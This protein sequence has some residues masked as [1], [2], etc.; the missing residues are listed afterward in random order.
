MML[1]LNKMKKIIVLALVVMMVLTGVVQAAEPYPQELVELKAQLKSNLSDSAYDTCRQ[2]LVPIYDLE[3]LEFFKYL[4]ETFE[5]KSANSTLTNLAI[6]R[7]SR[8]RYRLYET[9][10][11]LQPDASGGAPSKSLTLLSNYNRCS[12]ITQAYVDL[13]KAKLVEHVKKNSFQKRSTVLLEKYQAIGSRLKEMNQAIA[14]MYSNY[15]A[16]NNKLPGFLRQCIQN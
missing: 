3:L 13:G 15:V 4:E 12:E 8:Y 1:L 2:Q 5:N 14:E 6:A 10:S 9:F 7:Y 16:L 11:L